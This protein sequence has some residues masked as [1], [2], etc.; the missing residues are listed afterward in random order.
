MAEI[1]SDVTII[2]G[3]CSGLSLGYYYAIQ[4]ILGIKK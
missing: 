1:Y 3:G 4:I 2:G